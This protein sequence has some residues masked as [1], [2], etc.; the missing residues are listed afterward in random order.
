MNQTLLASYQRTTSESRLRHSVNPR[1]Q[2]VL[3]FID[4]FAGY[5]DSD[6]DICDEDECVY[7]VNGWNAGTA[8]TKVPGVAITSSL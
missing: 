2:V 8:D 4:R 5:S 3:F 1:T 6:L 7:C